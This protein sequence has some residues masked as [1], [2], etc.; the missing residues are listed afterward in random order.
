MRTARLGGTGSAS[1]DQ[2][3]AAMHDSL[4]KPV[5]HRPTF[6]V[7]GVRV[8]QARTGAFVRE[9]ATELPECTTFDER[10]GWVALP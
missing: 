2:D 1:V 4:A 10:C 8:F 3:C 6:K 7:Q 9:L 5:P